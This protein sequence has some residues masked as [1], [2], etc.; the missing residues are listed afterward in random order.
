MSSHQELLTIHS[1]GIY[2]GLPV[3]PEDLQGLTA[4][5]TGATGISGTYMLRVLCK[6]PKRWKKIYA[7]SSRPPYLDLPSHVE[8]IT[9]DFLQDP[10]TLAQQIRDKG[11][12]AD[13]VFFFAYIQPKPPA[14]GSIWSAAEELVRVNKTL[15]NN[16]LEG[17]AGA[18]AIPKRILLQL[19]A[20]YYG[21]HLG[22]VAV[23]EEESD[24]RVLLEPNFYYDQEDVLTA[25]CAAHPGCG[26]T[27]TR[28][29]WIPGAAASDGAMNLAFPLGVYAVVQRRLGQPLRFPGDAACWANPT[30][31]SSAML[32]AHLAEW[33]V[34]TDPA[35]NQSFNAS[36]DSAF[37]WAKFWPRYAAHF[38]A[39]W[40]GPAADD[41]A[42]AGF[43]EEQLSAPPRGWGPPG[44]L[45][46]S[47]T[48]V[49]WAKRAEV[50]AAWK[51]IAEEH[52]LASRDLGD[53]DRV[54][55]FADAALLTSWP[56]VYS[57]TKLRKA[58]FFGF[59][60]STESMF[61]VFDEFVGLKML[62][63]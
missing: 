63:R 5:V 39:S 58:G 33:A 13:Y 28:P 9:M 18:S 30:V 15:L 3:F 31:L 2:H 38:G 25:F 14:G 20:K 8:P 41:D 43:R 32:N 16:F 42:A 6:D 4:I 7:L 26:W 35:R 34:L 54:F 47:F 48:L 57:N 37:T 59:V 60:D 12:K 19:G 23:P 55:G 22:P 62:P 10:K 53:V 36:D 51:Q 1:D 45:R 11:V 17:L 49:E 46:F 24:P 44:V 40:E 29:S 21:V 56:S 52:G 61:S 50:V 27:T